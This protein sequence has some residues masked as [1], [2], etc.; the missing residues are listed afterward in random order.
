M[1]LRSLIIPTYTLPCTFHLW[2]LFAISYKVKVA[3]TGNGRTP[4]QQVTRAPLF[5]DRKIEE[6]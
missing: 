4:I 5:L 6:A 3:E 2:L 1:Q